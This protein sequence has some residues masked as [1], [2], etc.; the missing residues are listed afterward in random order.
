MNQHE[1]F[2]LRCPG[3]MKEK[4]EG[5]IC[6][7]CGFSEDAD[8]FAPLLPLKTV[9]EDR[10]LI[11]RAI[12]TNGEGV[13]YIGY[14]LTQ[15]TVVRVRE[16]LPTGLCTRENETHVRITAGNELIYNQGLMAFLDLARALAR[17]REL[18]ALLPVYD[19][20][21]SGGTAY[22]ICESVECITLRE[23]LL[24]NG[25]SLTWEQARPLIMP[26]LSAISIIHEAG[27]IHRGISP[28]TI[29]IGR[30]GKL[31]LT[32]FCIPDVRSARSDFSPQLYAGFAAIEQYGFE[33]TPGEWTDV[34]GFTATLYRV[35]VGNTPPEST[36]RVTND[37]LIIPAAVAERLPAYVM[38]AM[39][40]GLQ[41]MPADRTPDMDTLREELSAAPSVTT[42]QNLTSGAKAKAPQNE[43]S[44]EEEYEEEPKKNSGK[45]ALLA[46]AGTLVLVCVIGAVLM[47]TV[48]RDAIFGGEEPSSVGPEISRPPV[49]SVIS[50]APPESS[51]PLIAVPDFVNKV[52]SEITKDI[53]YTQ[54]FKFDTPS[55]ELSD[56]VPF[57]KVISQ[58]PK[59][60]EVVEK[61]TT[62]KLVISIGRKKIKLPQLR[63]LTR[64]QA[65][66]EL[67]KAG[68]N[69]E[70]IIF[71]KKW[72]DTVELDH[73]IEANPSENS[74]VNWYDT[75]TVFL[76]MKEPEE[77]SEPG[78]EFE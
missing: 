34:Y 50:L 22:Y 16:Y 38:N 67:L 25:G 28:E 29:L 53:R 74:T 11:G 23:F 64:E 52:Y 43:D 63:G 2:E 76:S 14:D 5:Q 56:T 24:R 42:R 66:Y 59:R 65:E 27:I 18:P 55:Y 44:D 57:G 19:I 30:D 68:V 40:G 72:D 32:G 20:F 21:E 7:Y 61:G 54:D 60:D 48:F 13:T 9:I 35:L 71:D 47:F 73:V 49:E 12:E 17:L 51:A 46:L 36:T 58:T 75:I 15:E 41:I 33:E 10:Y 3:C 78:F 1:D 37:R 70:N 39:S 4:P 69:R 6:P 45:Y 62:I 77:E 31:R 26:L 8:Q